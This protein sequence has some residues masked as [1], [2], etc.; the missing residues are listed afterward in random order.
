MIEKVLRTLAALHENH[1]HWRGAM[2]RAAAEL[3]L[4]EPN[5]DRARLMSRWREFTGHTPQKHEGEADEA[6]PE[7]S[8]TW[9]RY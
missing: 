8:L 4:G 1:P 5:G 7:R 9:G 3:I 6:S 2:D